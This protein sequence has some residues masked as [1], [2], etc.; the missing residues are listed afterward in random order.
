M[1]S[2]STLFVFQLCG[3]RIEQH[4]DLQRIAIDGHFIGFSDT[5]YALMASLLQHAKLPGDF[6]SCTE[7]SQ[8]F[9]RSPTDLHR[10]LSRY[11]SKIRDRLW[12]FKLDIL[13]VGDQGY[14]LTC[15]GE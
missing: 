12:L 6:A 14:M 1:A 15:K 13:H 10:L 8:V 9:P 2:Q 7:L 4:T 3:H 11:I 5:E